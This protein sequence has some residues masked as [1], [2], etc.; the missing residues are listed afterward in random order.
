MKT[1]QFVMK[2]IHPSSEEYSERSSMNKN[3]A[4]KKSERERKKIQQHASMNTDSKEYSGCL[5][6]WMHTFKCKGLK[7]ELSF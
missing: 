1:V 5:S 6:I 4:N 3:Y 7:I 2:F